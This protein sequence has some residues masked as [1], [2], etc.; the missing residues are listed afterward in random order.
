MKVKLEES[1]PSLLV[2]KDSNK[3]HLNKHFASK[4]FVKEPIV[5][6]V[7]LVIIAL[8]EFL[9]NRNMKLLLLA[10]L[11]TLKILLILMKS[12]V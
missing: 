11:L 4:Y 12:S 2:S 9:K 6:G 5:H 10:F 8:S 3:I 1:K 7:Y